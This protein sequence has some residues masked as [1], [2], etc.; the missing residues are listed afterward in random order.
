MSSSRREGYS[1]AV[2]EALVLGIPVCAVET[3]G[4]EELLGGRNTCGR[5]T[6]DRDEAL[7]LALKALLSDPALLARSREEAMA[8]GAELSARDGVREAEQ[9]LWNL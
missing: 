5:I 8:R 1:T 4:M 2:T 7:Y 3:A 9:L 6:E